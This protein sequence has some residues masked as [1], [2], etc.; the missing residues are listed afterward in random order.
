MYKWIHESIVVR[1][2]VNGGAVRGQGSVCDAPYL[3][4]FEGQA[5]EYVKRAVW[6]QQAARKRKRRL[7]VAMEQ[8]S[9]SMEQSQVESETGKRRIRKLVEAIREKMEEEGIGSR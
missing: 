9:K 7:T 5:I 6:H 2:R 8:V 4:I 3:G 1:R